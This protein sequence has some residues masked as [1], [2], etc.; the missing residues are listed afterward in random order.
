MRAL[1]KTT[2][3]LIKD[4]PVDVDDGARASEEMIVPIQIVRF[5]EHTQGLKR[6][7]QRD[8]L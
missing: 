3:V 4:A 6:S 1:K 8:P 2:I 5:Q 7:E